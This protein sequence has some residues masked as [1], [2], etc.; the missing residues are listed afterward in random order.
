MYRRGCKDTRM[1]V[2]A[3]TSITQCEGRDKCKYK[4]SNSSSLRRGFAI[5]WNLG[6]VERIKM[7]VDAWTLETQT[8]KWGCKGTKFLGRIFAIC[9]E[10]EWIGHYRLGGNA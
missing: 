8:N 5:C 7:E 2:D 9:W 10:L 4:G 3:R 1:D 6:W